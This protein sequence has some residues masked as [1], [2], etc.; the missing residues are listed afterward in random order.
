MLGA[1]GSL[2]LSGLQTKPSGGEAGEWHAL[3][4]GNGAPND[5]EN[6]GRNKWAAVNKGRSRREQAGEPPRWQPHG[7]GFGLRG[8]APEP[9]PAE[10]SVE[11]KGRGE[12]V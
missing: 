10:L 7:L 2:L 6:S 3:V 1:V 8:T 12:Y 9:Q 11:I 4:G 5:L